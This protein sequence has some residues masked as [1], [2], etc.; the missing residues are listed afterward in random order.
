MQPGFAGLRVDAFGT[1]RRSALNVLGLVLLCAG[2]VSAAPADPVA[3]AAKSTACLV[4]HGPA[5]VSSEPLIP[6][7]AGQPALSLVYQLIQ[8]REQRRHA[9]DMNAIAAPLS[10]QDMK[11][12][13]AHFAA[14]PPAPGKM[15][16]DAA[17]VETGRRIAQEQYCNSCHANALQGQ[18]HIPRL[19]GQSAAYLKQQLLNLKSGA[20]ADIDGTM[21]S[22][23]QVLS[24]ADM[25]AVAHYAASLG[26]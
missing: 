15:V 17:K 1:V 25:D 19:A 10:D 5:G 13:A 3:G 9:P 11:D 12:L 21:A 7:I 14:L 4:C 2:P 24:E 16:A 26:P 20:R 8:Y 22:A 6:S 18:K 23:A